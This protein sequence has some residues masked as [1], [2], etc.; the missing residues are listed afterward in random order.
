MTQ[1]ESRE[2]TGA[3]SQDSS[4]MTAQERLQMGEEASRLLGSDVYNVVYQRLLLS[5]FHRWLETHPKER[6]KRESMYHEALGLQSITMQMR[7]SVHDAQQIMSEQA[8]QKQPENYLDTQ[9]F[10]LNQ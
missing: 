10:G 7:A 3:K 8:E 9:G 1:N 4:S 6:E 2:T 5:L